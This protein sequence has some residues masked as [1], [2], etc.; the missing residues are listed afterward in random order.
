MLKF[1]VVLFCGIVATNVA[2][3]CE[4]VNNG[5]K[6]NAW[7]TEVCQDFSRKINSG[8]EDFI[9]EYNELIN[10]LEETDKMTCEQTLKTALDDAW[11]AAKTTIGGQ[12]PTE[13]EGRAQPETVDM[14]IMVEDIIK[15]INRNDYAI[16]VN[17]Y[18]MAGPE[19][20]EQLVRDLLDRNVKNAGKIIAFLDRLPRKEETYLGYKNLMLELKELNQTFSFPA[21]TLAYRA[22]LGKGMFKSLAEVWENLPGIVKTFPFNEP[23]KLVDKQFRENYYAS[24]LFFHE[25][26]DKR[27]PFN[28]KAHRQSSNIRLRPSGAIVRGRDDTATARPSTNKIWSVKTFNNGETFVIQNGEFPGYLYADII[29]NAFDS[30]RRRVFMTSGERNKYDEW[31]FEPM[32]NGQFRI[33]NVFWDEYLYSGDGFDYNARKRRVVTWVPGGCDGN[34]CLWSFLP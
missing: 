15:F 9:L 6:F 10:N 34:A 31:Q 4:L 3:N 17:S 30:D 23:F 1:V 18:K 32:K 21:M 16:A 7:H 5:N 20:L 8:K 2:V 29:E 28:D 13:L 24:N 33:K 11:M 19:L 26:P 22:K 25:D 27:K 14:N 12:T